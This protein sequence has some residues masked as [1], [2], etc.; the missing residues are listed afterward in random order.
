MKYVYTY[1]VNLNIY[2]SSIL[3][4]KVIFQKTFILKLLSF[5]MLPCEVLNLLKTVISVL[6]DVLKIMYT[7]GGGGYMNF[8]QYIHCAFILCYINL[9][10]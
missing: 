3:Y 10:Q 5:F 8:H 6:T 7:C 9:Y 1:I 4:L 2:T